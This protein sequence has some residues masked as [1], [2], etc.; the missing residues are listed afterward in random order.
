MQQLLHLISEN[1][2]RIR[3]AE[4]YANCTYIALCYMH[5][6]PRRVNIVVISTWNKGKEVNYQIFEFSSNPLHV[7]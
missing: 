1:F 5:M 7:S 4:A 3:F 2:I 6:L